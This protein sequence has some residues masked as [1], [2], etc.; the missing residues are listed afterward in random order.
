MSFFPEI[1]GAF[2]DFWLRSLA[3]LASLRSLV[4]GFVLWPSSLS[5]VLGFFLLGMS[6]V[7][8]HVPAA[9]ACRGA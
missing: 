5:L 7:P 1:V 9:E 6:L 3:F 4:F 8:M 2:F